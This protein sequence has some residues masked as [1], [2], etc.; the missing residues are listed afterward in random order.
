MKMAYSPTTWNT[1]D[2]ITK[3]KLN[4]IEQG[5][6]TGTLLSGTDIDADKDWNG[7][8]ITNVGT[9]S[10]NTLILPESPFTIV[11]DLTKN[12]KY[13]MKSSDSEAAGGM[14][15]WALAKSLPPLPASV[16]GTEN[17]VYV[18]YQHSSNRT[19]FNTVTQ[20]YV[21][22]A[23]VGTSRSNSSTSYTTWD[24]V[25]TGLKAGDIIQIYGR[26][27]ER[28][29]ERPY[30]RNLRVYGVIFQS[31]PMPPGIW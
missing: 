12:P 22:G 4:K 25:I 3:D 13:L 9:L 5:V 23:A 19:S 30:V 14:Y 18:S 21:N 11:P 28:E 26:G 31:T 17:S 6:K 15:D 20:I 29:G 7:K 2:V 1:N 8:N 27:G 16:Y 24:E 10:A